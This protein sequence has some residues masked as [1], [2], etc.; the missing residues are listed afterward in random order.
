MDKDIMVGALPRI[1]EYSPYWTTACLVRIGDEKVVDRIFNRASLSRMESTSID[2]LIEQYL[3]VLEGA[4]TDIRSGNSINRS[5]FGVIL[6]IVIPEILSRLC[7]KCSTDS[8]KKLVDFLLGVYQ[9]DYKQK[10]GGIWNLTKRL[11]DA[12][13]VRQRFD[14]IPKF[15]DFPIPLDLDISNNE[16]VNPF[17]FFS[18]KRD[19]MNIESEIYDK[20]LEV[21]LERAS[22]DNTGARKWAMWT[23]FQFHSWNLLE[24]RRTS[25]FAEILWSQLDE[26]GLPS[27]TDFYR[28]IFLDLPHPEGVD[29]V[30]SFK[31]YIRSE[32]SLTQKP[33]TEDTVPIDKVQLCI[34]TI[35]AN[36]EWSG[37]DV[38]FIFDRLVEWWNT[39]RIY[40]RMDYGPSLSAATIAEEYRDYLNNLVNVFESVILPNFYIIEDKSKKEILRHLVDEFRDYGLP[41]L[42]MEV[43]CLDIFPE[44][45][46]D[47]FGKIENG[48]AVTDCIRVTND[49]LDAVLSLVERT[50]MKTDN[51]E[52][53]RL[54]N[55]LGEMVRWQKG[56]PLAATLDTI[57][58]LLRQYDWAFS[59]ELERATLVSLHRITSNTTIDAE[60]PDV[61]ERLEVRQWA[62]RLAY[63][64]FEH[65]TKRG[66][67]IPD[68]IKEWETIC[69]SENEFAEVR[70]QWIRQDPE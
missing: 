47:V 57:L 42:R 35:N 23:L 11:I 49:S 15:L 18:T 58:G 33:K 25:Q 17:Y 46:D 38:N 5:N 30:L 63:E 59:D 45:K 6:A 14:L 26:Y 12:F 54:L 44:W 43:T 70:N 13:S 4:V 2:S 3:N 52:L 20:K 50:E 65:Y 62:A 55:M 39:D 34:E 31:K 67:P 32:W 27:Q 36:I 28:H 51:K 24:S 9:S 7:C 10:Y 41:A 48:M 22:S 19:L 16:F 61:S 66:D 8:K 29:P 21:F 68:V 60:V 1:A 37:D 40:L 69:Q 56:T 53:T 64:L